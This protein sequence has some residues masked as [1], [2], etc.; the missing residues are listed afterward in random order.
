MTSQLELNSRAALCKQLAEREPANRTLWLAEAENWLRLSKDK[1]LAEATAFHRSRCPEA[2]DGGNQCRGQAIM[3]P[4]REASEAGG[5]YGQA[6]RLRQ[7]NSGVIFEA[8]V[9]GDLSTA[10]GCRKMQ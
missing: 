3:V 2:S 10:A 5:G 6:D 9:P 4:S 7:T 8:F 1:L